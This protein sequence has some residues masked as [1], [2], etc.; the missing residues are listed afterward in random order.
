MDACM[1]EK[2]LELCRDLSAARDNSEKIGARFLK[3]WGIV[4]IVAVLGT[5]Y[6]VGTEKKITFVDKTNTVYLP[7]N[8]RHFELTKD[9]IMLVF[10]WPLPW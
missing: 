3:S 5:L 1:K 8:E 2:N 6:K 4:N 7:G 10:L 9:S